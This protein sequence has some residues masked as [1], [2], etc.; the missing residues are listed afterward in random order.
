MDIS[1]S[2]ELE[3]IDDGAEYPAVSQDIFEV[4]ATMSFV[5]W[6]G[7]LM[8]AGASMVRGG[9]MMS[10]VLNRPHAD[11]EQGIQAIAEMQRQFGLNLSDGTLNNL[12]TLGKYFP[13]G[14]RNLAL[15]PRH[16][17]LLVPLMRD[18]PEECKKVMDRAAQEGW[19]TRTLENYLKERK[20]EKSEQPSDASGSGLLSLYYEMKDAWVRFARSFDNGGDLTEQYNRARQVKAILEE[21]IEAADAALAG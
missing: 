21:F 4:P 10:V 18:D 5:E 6:T 12:K 2:S 17:T 16:H 9:W 13:P 19:Y 7:R 8:I 11:T 3:P 15:S 1:N 20:G 14:K